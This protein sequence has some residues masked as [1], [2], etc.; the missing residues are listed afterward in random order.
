MEAEPEQ[1]L[2]NVIKEVTRLKAKANVFS[3]GQDYNVKVSFNKI[4]EGYDIKLSP[5]FANKSVALDK[6]MEFANLTTVQLSEFYILLFCNCLLSTL[7]TP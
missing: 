2:S 5:L 4:V 3:N 1:L 6:E 7:Y